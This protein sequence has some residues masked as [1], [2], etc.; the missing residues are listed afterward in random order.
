MANRQNTNS[1]VDCFAEWSTDSVHPNKGFVCFVRLFF[2]GR[3]LWSDFL[4]KDWIWDDLWTK[5]FEKLI[6]PMFQKTTFNPLHI[7][8]GNAI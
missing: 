5:G 6:N 4:R 8:A 2:A 7:F 3:R 1:T